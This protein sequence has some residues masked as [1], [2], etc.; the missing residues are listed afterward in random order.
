[1][2][3][4]DATGEERGQLARTFAYEAAGKVRRHSLGTSRTV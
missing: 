3:A 1:M 2:D 4:L